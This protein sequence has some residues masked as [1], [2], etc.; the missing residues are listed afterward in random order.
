MRL[1]YAFMSFSCPQASL[2]EMLAMARRY[3]YDGIEPRIDAGHTHGI[4]PNIAGSVRQQIQQKALDAVVALCCIATSIHFANP[5]E[6]ADQIE[7]ARIRIDLAGDLGAPRLRVFG[8]P[9]PQGTSREQAIDLIADS[10]EQI[11]TQAAE[12][13]VVVCMETHDDWCNPMHVAEVMKRVDHPAIGVNWDI[14]HPVRQ[15]GTNMDHA[16]QILKPWIRHVHFHDGLL[17][18]DP[19]VLKPVGEGKVDHQRAVQLLKEMNYDGY[20]SGEWI[21]WEPPEVHLP[22]ELTAMKRYENEA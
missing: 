3:G 15:G 22:R 20:L 6:Q 16:F 14:M 7:Q 18:P 17:K 10:L 5:A 12:R 9:I 21:D 19:V 1:K 13:N 8:G 4:E 11:A 2:D